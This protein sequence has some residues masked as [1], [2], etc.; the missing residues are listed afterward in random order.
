M[1]PETV[2][3]G[4]LGRRDLRAALAADDHDLVADAR[5]GHVAEID[6]RVLERVLALGGVLRPAVASSGGGSLTFDV[7]RDGATP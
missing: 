6:A 7:A 3:L 4:D 5:V 2:L 1:Q